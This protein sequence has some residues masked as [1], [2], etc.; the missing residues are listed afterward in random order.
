MTALPFDPAHPPSDPPPDVPQAMLWRVAVRL[1]QDH[2]VLVRDSRGVPACARCGQAW[3]C[4]GRRLA[5][6]GLLAAVRSTADRRLSD[7]PESG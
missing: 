5:L 2:G 4:F 1:H 6:R 7:G 3:P